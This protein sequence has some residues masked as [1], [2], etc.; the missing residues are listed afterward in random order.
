MIKVL[1]IVFEMLMRVTTK[2]MMTMLV[3]LAIRVESDCVRQVLRSGRKAGSRV[4]KSV[5]CTLHSVHVQ[6]V[7]SIVE[8]KF[9]AVQD[10]VCTLCLAVQR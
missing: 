7:M 10:T 5:Q 3:V 2:V 4:H 6:C 8:F 9:R 1:A